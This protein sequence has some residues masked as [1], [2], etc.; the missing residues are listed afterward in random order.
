MGIMNSLKTAWNKIKNIANS[1]KKIIQK[2]FNRKPEKLADLS[3]SQLLNRIHEFFNRMTCNLPDSAFHWTID[4]YKNFLAEP[5]LVLEYKEYNEK[6]FVTNKDV[7]HENT[8]KERKEIY[9][10]GFKRT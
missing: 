5:F 10:K 1:I 8:K 4:D 2:V 7:F 9:G 6:E 3:K